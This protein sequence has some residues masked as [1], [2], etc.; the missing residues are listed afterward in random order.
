VTRKRFSAGE[1]RSSL[2]AFHFFI[3][4]LFFFPPIICLCTDDIWA[5]DD[6]SKYLAE[7][8]RAIRAENLAGSALPSPPSPSLFG[9][10]R[11]KLSSAFS[12]EILVE[13]ESG[14]GNKGQVE[15][16]QGGGG[17]GGGGG[18]PPPYFISLY[19]PIM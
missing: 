8:D 7:F 3:F 16:K 5:A 12:A 1:G 17:G 10:L 2:A 4:F 11:R 6:L 18:G 9:A 13:V 14:S 19:Q 15:G